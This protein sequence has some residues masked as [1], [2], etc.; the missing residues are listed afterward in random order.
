MSQV[1]DQIERAADMTAGIVA[2]IAADQWDRPT[3]CAGWDVRTLLNHVVGG[4]RIFAAKLD[5]T[6]PGADHEADW[7]GADPVGAYEKAAAAD[8]AAWRRPDALEQTVHIS[9]GVLPGP[10]AAV[11]HLTEIL[12]HGLDLAIATG[13]ESLVDEELCGDLLV[14][15]RSMGIDAYRIPGVFGP[16]TQ[17]AED[18]PLHRQLLAFLGRAV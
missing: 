5:G 6:D 12:V 9:L 14:T 15:M 2:G 18:A 16:E 17:T 4:M 10:L 13:Q 8:R 1:V 11:V 7:L 3:P